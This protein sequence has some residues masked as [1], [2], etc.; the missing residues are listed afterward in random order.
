LSTTPGN[1][2]KIA[3]VTTTSIT[4]NDINALYTFNFKIDHSVPIG[5]YFSIILSN[6][7]YGNG[8]SITNPQTIQNECYMI[9]SKGS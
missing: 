1:V 9:T 7:T 6:D 3:D 5:G 8:A 2:K 4:T